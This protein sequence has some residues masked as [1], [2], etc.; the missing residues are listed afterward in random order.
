MVECSSADW[1]TNSSLGT[2][3]SLRNDRC[4]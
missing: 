3:Y 4:D 1:R 2:R